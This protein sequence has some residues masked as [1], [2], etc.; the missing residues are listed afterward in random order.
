MVVTTKD[1]T[2][3]ETY[4]NLAKTMQGLKPYVTRVEAYPSVLVVNKGIVV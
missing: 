2:I 4:D 3:F 1:A